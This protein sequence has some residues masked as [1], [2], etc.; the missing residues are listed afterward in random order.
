MLMKVIVLR[1]TDV[2]KQR[3]EKVINAC[4]TII[5]LE[6]NFKI[7]GLCVCVII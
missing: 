4:Y 2:G 1:N 3:I 6:G 7:T 5:S